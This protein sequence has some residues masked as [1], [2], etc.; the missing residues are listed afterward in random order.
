MRRAEGKRFAPAYENKAVDIPAPP[1]IPWLGHYRI[2]C[3][4]GAVIASCSHLGHQ[5]AIATVPRGCADC[6]G[7]A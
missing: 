4:C 3:D 2:V 7:V 6:Q 5:Y 1:R